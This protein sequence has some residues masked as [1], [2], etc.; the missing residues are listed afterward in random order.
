MSGDDVAEMLYRFSCSQ[1]LV[2]V[3]NIVH[4]TNRPNNTES[5]Y[6]WP[7]AKGSTLNEWYPLSN[8]LLR[9]VET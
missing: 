5:I 6:T 8:I 2:A 4:G 1:S 3:G 7:E 9:V